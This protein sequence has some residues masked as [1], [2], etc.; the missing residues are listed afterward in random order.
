MK[1]ISLDITK[2]TQFLNEGVVKAYEPQV[3]A[4]HESLEK[5]PVP[6]TIFS[7]GCIFLLLLQKNFLKR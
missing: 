2:A 7:D 4:A 1:S 5:E 3:I 6:E